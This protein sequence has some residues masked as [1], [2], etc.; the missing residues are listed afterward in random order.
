MLGPHVSLYLLQHVCIAEFLYEVAS[1]SPGSL[2]RAAMTGLACARQCSPEPLGKPLAEWGQTTG[3]V[4]LAER[5]RRPYVGSL[6]PAC[7]ACLDLRPD[8]G[9]SALDPQCY[10]GNQT[11]VSSVSR[12]LRSA[13]GK[14]AHQQ[15]AQFKRI[16]FLDGSFSICPAAPTGDDFARGRLDCTLY[17]CDSCVGMWTRTFT[18]ATCTAH[19]L[20]QQHALAT[21]LHSRFVKDHL[22]GAFAC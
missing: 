9:C 7:G 5:S 11:M 19:R 13:A 14:H 6:R 21:H 10:T 2:M 1:R 20:G 22:K 4:Y 12:W 8:R 18:K 15:H 3:H 16:C 17:M